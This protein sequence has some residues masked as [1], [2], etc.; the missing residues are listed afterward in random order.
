[1]NN[2][3]DNIRNFDKMQDEREAIGEEAKRLMCNPDVLTLTISFDPN[4]NE[5]FAVLPNHPFS[6]RQTAAQFLG[7]LSF[8]QHMISDTAF[9]G[10][11]FER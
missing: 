4:G 2:A 10:S 9:G 6:E 11:D 5:L 7:M 1:M 8:A 3:D